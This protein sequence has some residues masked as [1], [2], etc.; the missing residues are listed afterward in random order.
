MNEEF[1]FRIHCTIMKHSH[2]IWPFYLTVMHI[3]ISQYNCILM[4]LVPRIFVNCHTKEVH[5]PNKK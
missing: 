1:D 2:V 4:I 3:I 5:S